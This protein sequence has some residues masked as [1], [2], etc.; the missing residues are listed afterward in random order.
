[1]QKCPRRNEKEVQNSSSRIIEDKY[2]KASE[3]SS[4]HFMLLVNW[5]LPW[6]IDLGWPRV[7]WGNRTSFGISEWNISNESPARSTSQT[8]ISLTILINSSLLELFSFV[9]WDRLSFNSVQ[10]FADKDLFKP[11]FFFQ[12]SNITKITA[13]CSFLA[14]K[15]I[16]RSQSRILAQNS[17]FRSLV[18]MVFTISWWPF[19]TA[20]SKRFLS[21]TQKK[22]QSKG[23]GR[24]K[25]CDRF[26]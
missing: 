24:Q 26:V 13:H 3:A 8:T 7:A 18:T 5:M 16:I 25:S 2:R 20:N 6:R 11:R 1:M 15:V 17:L 14:D 9:E 19:S 4:W 12:T 21:N 23:R 22:I 10:I